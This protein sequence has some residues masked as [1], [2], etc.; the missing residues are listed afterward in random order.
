MLERRRGGIEYGEATHYGMGIETI[1]R[2]GVQVLH[3]GGALPGWGSDWFVLPEAGVGVVLLMNSESGR[4]VEEATHRRLVELLYGARPEAEASVRAGAA[5]MR[6]DVAEGG[7]SIRVPPDA[8][9][10][11]RLATRYNNP[12]LGEMTV[13]RD[14]AG[15]T[16]RFSS[17]SS[18]VGTRTNPDGSVTFVM[19]DPATFNWRLRARPAGDHDELVMR[20][21]QREYVFSPSS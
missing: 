9:A 6:A 5:A 16:F 18:R 14:A 7:R 2:W 4:D 15:V 21:A 20:D 3:H 13:E 17:V 19:V 8:R 1:A 10:V 12:S 11:A